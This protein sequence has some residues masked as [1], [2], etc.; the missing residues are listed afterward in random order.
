MVHFGK[1]E[2]EGEKKFSSS[3]GPAMQTGLSPVSVLGQKLHAVISTASVSISSSAYD[4]AFC[5]QISVFR[6]NV[7]K[8]QPCVLCYYNHN[9]YTKNIDLKCIL[10][11]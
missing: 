4:T 2:C 3:S 7:F 10:T 1:Q 5:I 6:E 8:N 9:H 11:L